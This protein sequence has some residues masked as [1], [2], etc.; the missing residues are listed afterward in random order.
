MAAGLLEDASDA[1]CCGAYK[2][3]VLLKIA[4]EL[5]LLLTLLPHLL[6]LL[7]LL[8]II[9]VGLL[10]LCGRLALLLRL[11]LLALLGLLTLLRLL[12]LVP[13]LRRLVIRVWLAGT[14]G[15]SG[16]GGV[17]GY[18]RPVCGLIPALLGL[19]TGLLAGNLLCAR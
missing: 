3:E 19:L 10:G 8:L 9:I 16:R 14:L 17:V 1:A 6:V 4:V 7:V 15:V 13:L 12:R 5:S 11:L 2:G 18:L